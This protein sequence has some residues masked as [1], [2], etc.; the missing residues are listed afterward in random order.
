MDNPFLRQ[1]MKMRENLH[2]KEVVAKGVSKETK[3][4]SDPTG[5]TIAYIIENK[6]PVKEVIDYFKN[7]CDQ[8][9]E[10]ALK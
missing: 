9:N 3:T 4:M 5:V 6:P 1:F 2:K 8:F 7:R 10:E